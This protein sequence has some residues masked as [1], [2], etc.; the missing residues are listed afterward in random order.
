MNNKQLETSFFNWVSQNPSEL[1]NKISKK[2]F[3]N[4][5][6]QETLLLDKQTGKY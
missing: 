5:I 4:Y 6:A 3:E 2:A 1:K